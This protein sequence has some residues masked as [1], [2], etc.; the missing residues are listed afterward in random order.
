MADVPFSC[1]D[2][3]SGVTPCQHE[4]VNDL[5]VHGELFDT[6]NE[7]GC[8]VAMLDYFKEAILLPAAIFLTSIAVLE[9][10]HI[11]V[12]HY[13]MT[14]VGLLLKLYHIMCA[15]MLFRCTFDTH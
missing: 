8:Q 6:L 15:Y 10:C 14:Y 11:G 7:D 2:I 4:S 5:S 3:E 12:H 1:C 9:V 13:N